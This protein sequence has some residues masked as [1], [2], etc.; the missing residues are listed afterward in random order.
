MMREV[1]VDP[2][3]AV[4]T[5]DVIAKLEARRH[6]TVQLTQRLKVLRTDGQ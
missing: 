6:P 5:D 3:L 2:L 1:P 4:F